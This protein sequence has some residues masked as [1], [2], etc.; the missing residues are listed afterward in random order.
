MKKKPMQSHLKQKEKTTTDYTQL[1]IHLFL[2]IL[3]ILIN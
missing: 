3:C 2:W 1:F